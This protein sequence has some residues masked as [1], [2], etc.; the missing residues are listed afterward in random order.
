MLRSLMLRSSYRLIK[1]FYLFPGEGVVTK[2]ASGMA[3]GSLKRLKAALI[4]HEGFRANTPIV[5]LVNPESVAM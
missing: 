3:V 1:I 5:K 4:G 2:V